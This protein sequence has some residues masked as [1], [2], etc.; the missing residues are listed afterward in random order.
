MVRNAQT[1]W[2]PWSAPGDWMLDPS[3]IKILTNYSCPSSPDFAARA[4]KP[5]PKCSS[6]PIPQTARRAIQFFNHVWHPLPDKLQQYHKH[7]QS[8][9][10][11]RPVD[12]DTNITRYSKP[13]RMR[14]PVLRYVRSIRCAIELVSIHPNES[15]YILKFPEIISLWNRVLSHIESFRDSTGVIMTNVKTSIFP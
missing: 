12:R 13:R 8:Q 14:L 1:L 9:I 10:S 2:H 7:K 15:T 5:F 6:T 11:I 4:S 3:C